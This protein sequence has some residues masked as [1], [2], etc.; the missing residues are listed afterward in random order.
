MTR[1]LCRRSL[2]KIGVSPL[3]H[4][5][6]I[7][8]GSRPRRPNP[9][10]LLARDRADPYAQRLRQGL[11][12]QDRSRIQRSNQAGSYSPALSY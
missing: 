8:D 7:D 9:A 11:P 5:F 1:V 12:R 4:S 10:P 6:H 3:G 2:I